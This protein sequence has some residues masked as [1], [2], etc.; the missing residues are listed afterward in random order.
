MNRP[1]QREPGQPRSARRRGAGSRG[2]RDDSRRSEGFAPGESAGHSV[3][4]VHQP[5]GVRLQKVL[6]Q[7][8]VGSRRACEQL[9]AD[10]KVSVDG[11]PVFELGV[12]VDPSS[13]VIHVNGLRVLVENTE[14]YVVL[15]KPAGVVT[16][17]SDPQG[18]PTV[19]DF[20]QDLSQRVFPVG[21]LDAA[22]EGLLLLT[23]DGELAHRLAHPSYEVRKTYVAVVNGSV[24]P[25]VRGILLKGVELEDG[26]TAVDSFKV[27]DRSK[28]TSLVE[29]VLHSGKNR[30]VRR[31]LDKVGHPVQKLVRTAI[32]PISLG[33]QRP[34]TVR[35]LSSEDIAK[36]MA[37]VKM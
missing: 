16:T 35:E 22:T 24:A 14:T 2:E 36:L 31:L 15:N 1:W 27:R 9:I 21:R 18:R 10:G 7:A 32:G 26:V 13:A 19:A 8:G 30:I 5:G 25:E 20:V 28:G 17:M 4:D 12:R 34:G 23:S 3:Q 33:N 37:E 11:Q 6:A 29:V